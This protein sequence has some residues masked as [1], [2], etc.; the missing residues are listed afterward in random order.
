MTAATT[1]TSDGRPQGRRARVLR[2]ARRSEVARPDH[3]V[4][5]VEPGRRDLLGVLAALAI[6]LA[7]TALPLVFN[8]SYYFIDDT[9]G[10]A[11]GQWYE[12][13]QQLRAGHWPM[14]SVES[15]M[16]G[17]HIAE[18][19]W[20]LYNPVIWAIALITTVAPQAA[21]VAAGVKLFFL[22]LAA[23]GIYLLTRS[24]G[25]R[26][27]L[28]V[29][30]A[31]SAPVAGW[32]F[33]L[34]ATAWVTN[35]EVWAYFPWTMW[36]V[37]RYMHNRRGIAIALVSGLLLVTVGYVQGTVMLVLMFL[38][39]A[40]EAI[41]LRRWA[42]LGRMLLAG[43]PIGL[44]AVT[45][46]L[47]GVLS[48][49]V[50]VRADEVKN[51]GFMTLTLNGL[52]VSV[53]P[54]GRADLSGWW[55][56]YPDLPYTYIAWFL[57]LALLVSARR[58]RALLPRLAGLIALFLLVLVLAIGPSDLGPLRFPIRSMPWVAL[59]L[60]V[61]ASVLLSRAVDPTRLRAKLPLAIGAVVLAGWLSY[62][63]VIDTWRIQ[64]IFPALCIALMLGY[65]ALAASG[66]RWLRR[67][68]PVG[69]VLASILLSGM[70]TRAYV[71]D[72]SAFGNTGFPT[73]LAEYKDAVTGTRGELI[74]VG[75]P[76]ELQDR[77]L[78]V[79]SL[80][81]STW[82]L[83]DVPAVNA[84]SP[85]GYLAFNVDLCMNPY[86]GGTCTELVHTLFER[87]PDTGSTLADLMS[88]DTVQL[89]ASGDTTISDLEALPVPEGWEVIDQD[90]LSVTWAR[91]GPIEPVGGPT[92][93]TEGMDVHVEHQ[94]A[95]GVR[96][97]VHG[98]PAEGGRIVLS[99]LDWPGYRVEGGTHADPLRGYLL[100]V[101]VPP[102]SEG[103]IVEVTFRPPGWELEVAALVASLTLSVVLIVVSG[104][105][106]G[107]ARRSS[108]RPGGS[109]EVPGG[110][111]SD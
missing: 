62:S 90:A 2:R 103:Q 3:G 38:A 51:T 64:I 97:R 66:R 96:M 6:T 67:A 78:W 35:L 12:L 50:T 17:N 91:T 40:I 45:V 75:D 99:R 32:T 1:N 10:G 61:L 43:I 25:A 111:T 42:A 58:V 104:V 101:D 74:A 102:G 34:D 110:K 83:S 94:D 85:T 41:V 84:Y 108:R 69:L 28:A 63:A 16:A 14:L 18:G 29:L 79:D 33:Y 5:L 71:Q 4:S 105:G 31:I 21:V 39:L 68:A 49:A 23:A 19:Q 15:W 8:P 87:D 98:V 89:L 46:Y 92:W 53:N 109:G 54:S 36:A 9:A 82:Y 47:P 44:M 73:E 24:Y 22:A 57:P 27:V 81:G 59:T 88:I 60:I 93:S 48:S 107:R 72:A 70:Q 37:R 95:N 52:A 13:G 55:G 20:G 77:G 7:L 11:Y 106:W 30:A 100:T 76:S 86:Y 80:W 56:R 65:A 26:P